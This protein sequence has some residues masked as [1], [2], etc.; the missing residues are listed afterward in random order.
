MMTV[1]AIRHQFI[2]NNKII[3]IIVN[4]YVFF[5]YILSI[6]YI[7]YHDT[8]LLAILQVRFPSQNTEPTFLVR[9]RTPDRLRE[10]PMSRV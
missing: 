2:R 3:T 4:N 10:S 1:Y 6:N 9:H 8:Q 7:L 5:I